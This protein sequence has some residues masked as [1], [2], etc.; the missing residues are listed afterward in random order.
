[1]SLQKSF[2]SLYRLLDWADRDKSTLISFATAVLFGCYA[3]WFEVAGN[4]TEFA[5]A[6][7]APAMLRM[8]VQLNL[9]MVGVWLCMGVLGLYF[10]RRN[11]DPYLFTSAFIYLY[12]VCYVPLGHMIGLH[13]PLIGIVAL[14]ASLTGFILFDFRRVALS[15][16]VAMLLLL[17]LMLLTVAGVLEYAPLLIRDPVGKQH[18][19]LFWVISLVLCAVPFVAMVFALV[20]LVLVRWRAR[21]ARVLLLSATDVLTGLANRRALFEQVEHE[22]ARTRRSGASLSLC[23]L[24][25]DHFKQVNDEY[26]HGAGDQVLVAVAQR[27]Q[28][29]LRE[30]DLVGRIGGEEFVLLLP[31]TPATVAMGAMERCRQLIAATPV[32]LDDGT[33]LAVTASFGVVSTRGDEGLGLTQLLAR[34]DEALYAAKRGGRNCVSLWQGERVPAPG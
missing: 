5:G 23:V 31:S 27:L 33:A 3:L 12:G 19:S 4:L 25:L 13:N 17:G 29:S 9:A 16:A 20:T 28:Q 14:G 1:L 11:R 18:V 7:L 10:R 26:G 24:D 8:T 2:K 30:V 21:E 15:F 22:L 32:R 6:Y 34:A